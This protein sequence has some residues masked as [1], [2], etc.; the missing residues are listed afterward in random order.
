MWSTDASLEPLFLPPDPRSRI[1]SCPSHITPLIVNRRRLHHINRRRKRLPILP[2][3][4]PDFHPLIRRINP[5]SSPNTQPLI[6]RRNSGRCLHTTLDHC[7]RPTPTCHEYADLLGHRYAMSTMCDS[8]THDH[9]TTNPSVRAV[10]DTEGFGPVTVNE[11]G[12]GESCIDIR[13]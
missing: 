3:P 6:H 13:C 11:A 10:E 7:P 1:P 9:E 4:L 12:R 2:S 5:P 8:G